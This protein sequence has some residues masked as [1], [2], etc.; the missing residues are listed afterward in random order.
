MPYYVIS[1]IVKATSKVLLTSLFAVTVSAAST[2]IFFHCI[3][4]SADPWGIGTFF[5]ILISSPF[6]PLDIPIPT[7]IP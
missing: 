2:T 6:A 3:I 4:S 1:I 5:N 7:L